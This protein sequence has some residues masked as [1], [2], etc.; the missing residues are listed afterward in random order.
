[1]TDARAGITL[2][3]ALAVALAIVAVFSVLSTA[4][5][6][7]VTVDGVAAEG[8][9]ERLVITGGVEVTFDGWVCKADGGTYDAAAKTFILTGNV[10]LTTSSGVFSGEQAVYDWAKGEVVLDSGVLA[11]TVPDSVEPIYVK[12]GKIVIN[13]ATA[14]F[15]LSI[16]TSCD[17]E[18]PHWFLKCS[19]VELYPSDKVVLRG[20]VFYEMGIPLFW[21]P[22]MILPLDGSPLQ[23]P[24][25]GYTE[26]TG[27]YFSASANYGDESSGGVARLDIFQKSG[28]GAG[29]NHEKKLS[30][31][32]TISGS[33]YF[34]RNWGGKSYWAE[35]GAGLSHKISDGLEV[36]VSATYRPYFDLGALTKDAVRVE[37]SVDYAQGKTKAAGKYKLIGSTFP[38][39]F[40]SQALDGSVGHSFS[41]K[42]RLHAQLSILDKSGY[43][44]DS[45]AIDDTIANY[46]VKLRYGLENGVI[47]FSMEDRTEY[48]ASTYSITRKKRL[49]KMPELSVEDVSVNIPWVA[50]PLSIDLLVGNYSYSPNASANSVS[51]SR[52]S[53]KVE[54]ASDELIKSEHFGLSYSFSAGL[55]RYGVGDVLT[56]AAPKATAGL[57]YGRF[58]ATLTHSFTGVYG[59][60]PLLFDEVKPVN[61]LTL[62]TAYSI[63]YV[64]AAVRTSYD[65]NA[66][67]M[68]PVEVS[69]DYS[70]GQKLSMGVSYSHDL[71]DQRPHSMALRY[72]DL[73]DENRSVSMDLSYS[74]ESLSVLKAGAEI[75]YK[76]NDKLRLV[77]AIDYDGE[78]D[79]WNMSNVAL[80][81]DLHCREIGLRYDISEGRVWLDY[82]LY[83]FPED[84]VKVGL[85]KGGG[86][87]LE[88]S[89]F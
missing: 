21:W 9:L 8:T 78:K 54:Q 76:L 62:G 74:F 89:I 55:S 52:L 12:A 56:Y 24:Q 48:R 34:L 71:V 27:L 32:L 19:S 43:T 37:A 65:F 60:T 41:D 66:D 87:L 63:G 18:R 73:R 85:D 80:V 69:L 23:M 2:R 14:V 57:S 40:A 42:L 79:V 13:E 61:K 38:D 3:C 33:T 31:D 68:D 86:V 77:T 10:Q 15:G 1:M 50:E 22:Y 20:A 7:P 53:V 36:G 72:T 11:M 45:T 81:A 4:C 30:E 5:A 26:S 49:A 35:V 44:E 88:S 82:R 29:V 25:I 83:A 64:T 70:P 75:S 46:S 28:I 17:L 67:A 58:A 47:G 16:V 39:K 84:S 6:A 59:K 51:D